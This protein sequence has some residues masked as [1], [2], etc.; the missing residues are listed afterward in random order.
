MAYRYVED[1]NS[2]TLGYDQGKTV[3][4]RTFVVYNDT[5]GG[6]STL[7]TPEQVT[8]LYGSTDGYGTYLP[9]YGSDYPNVI[10]LKAMSPMTG[11]KAGHNDVWEVRWRYREL[12]WT[13]TD[14]QPNEVGYVGKTARLYGEPRDMWVSQSYSTIQ[15]NVVDVGS[16]Y[17]YGTPAATPGAQLVYSEQIDVT[18]VPTTVSWRVA[19]VT[20]SE[21][22]NV[23]PNMSYVIA[24]V[25]RRNSVACFGAQK[26]M[27][28]LAGADI[29][30]LDVKLWRVSYRFVI[31]TMCHLVQQPDRTADSA[32]LLDVPGTFSHA[33]YVRAVQPFPDFADFRALSPAIGA[34]LT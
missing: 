24:F 21:T 3:G 33:K 25:N 18:G 19:E 10:G 9:A 29:S 12:D 16:P 7:S 5:T 8:A 28:L 6:G 1:I 31:D 32:V 34:A 2:R 26:G 22:V 11:R 14:K 30:D 17:R 27:V 20:L 23:F 13:Q 4:E 15:Q